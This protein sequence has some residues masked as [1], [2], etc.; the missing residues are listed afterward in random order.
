M[1]L[2]MVIGQLMVRRGRLVDLLKAVRLVG[3]MMGRLDVFLVPFRSRLHG[4]VYAA[5]DT[6]YYWYTNCKELT[7]IKS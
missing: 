2:V 4:P 5:S 6:P 3:R 7:A 1:R